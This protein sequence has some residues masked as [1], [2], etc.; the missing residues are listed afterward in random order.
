MVENDTGYNILKWFMRNGFFQWLYSLIHP[1]IGILLASRTSKSSREYTTKKDFGELD[2]L[3]ESAKRKIEEG[4]DYVIF[5]HLHKKIFQN[6]VRKFGGLIDLFI[7][8]FNQRLFNFIHVI[9][10]RILVLENFIHF[11]MNLA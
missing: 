9:L 11:L 1:D 5:G 6:F 3:Y 10:I 7:L 2:G 8:V 4:Y